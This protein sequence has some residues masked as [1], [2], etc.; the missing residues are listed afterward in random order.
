MVAELVREA[1]QWVVAVR[2]Q[3]IGI[4]VG[5]LTGAGD[6]DADEAWLVICQDRAG[7]HTAALGLSL[8]TAWSSAHSI[9][10]HPKSP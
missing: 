5:R 2:G 4:E 6:P 3:L 10:E 9:T 8:G 7:E 1:R